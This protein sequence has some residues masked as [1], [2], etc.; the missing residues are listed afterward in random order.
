MAMAP[1]KKKKG[2]KDLNYPIK[3]P[4]FTTCYKAIVIGAVRFGFKDRQ[5]D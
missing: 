3:L 4:N 1:L 5:I 2:L